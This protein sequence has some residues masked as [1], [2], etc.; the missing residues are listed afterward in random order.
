MRCAWGLYG[1]EKAVS[2]GRG[3][4]STVKILPMLL[5]FAL[6]C[7]NGASDA[8]RLKQQD[9]IREAVFRYQFA[10]NASGQQTGAAV[11]CLWVGEKATDPSDDFMRRFANHKPPVRKMSECK[12]DPSHG[13]I[14]KRTGAQ[15]LGF[16]AT[17]IKWLSDIEVEVEGGY[18]EAGLS[19]SGNTYIVNKQKGKWVVSSDRMNWI[20]YRPNPLRLLPS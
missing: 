6:A 1:K 9:D 16:R 3:W 5:A 8:D 12:A 20:A 18:Y 13:V 7:T 14:D 19:A 2:S 10:H 17:S 11:Y 15:G 4:W